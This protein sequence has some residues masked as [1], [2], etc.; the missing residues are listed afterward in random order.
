LEYD[1]TQEPEDD[2]IDPVLALRQI[3]FALGTA[4]EPG[5]R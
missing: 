5:Y 3:V 4:A 1:V 2:E